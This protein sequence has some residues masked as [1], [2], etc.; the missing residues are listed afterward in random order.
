MFV[1]YLLLQIVQISH[2]TITNTNQHYSQPKKF[3]Y[4]V[5]RQS[6]T[7]HRDIPLTSFM[8]GGEELISQSEVPLNNIQEPSGYLKRVRVLPLRACPM[9]A[10]EP[11]P[12][13]GNTRACQ[14][15]A[16]GGSGPRPGPSAIGHALTK[17]KRESNLTTLLYYG[18]MADLTFDL[19]QYEWKDG[20]TMMTYSAKKRRDF[21]RQRT[22][23]INLAES[24]WTRVLPAH[25]NFD[26]KKLWDR[27]RVR[28]ESTLIWLMWHHG[29]AVN[30][31]R[32]SINAEFNG[33]CSLGHPHVD[34]EE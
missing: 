20:S 16:T 10:T 14:M 31:W 7:L 13:P 12:R 21:L 32:H 1:T 2:I 29:V 25:F 22:P 9:G 11:G 26:W 5:G 4:S 28:K 23:S 33:D 15:G 3:F 24:K 6:L 19:K 27:T 18:P 17:G 8:K 34:S 30:A